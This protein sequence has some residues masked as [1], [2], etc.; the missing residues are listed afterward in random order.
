MKLRVLKKRHAR[1]EHAARKFDALVLSQG[2]RVW[3]EC[4]E[5]SR[6]LRTDDRLRR[7]MRFTRSARTPTSRNEPGSS[8]SQA[9]STARR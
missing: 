4:V 3:F 5:I 8:R 1:M 9:R 2:E 7:V 6:D